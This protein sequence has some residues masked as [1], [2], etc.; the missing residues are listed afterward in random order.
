M[1]AFHSVYESRFTQDEVLTAGVSSG[2][3]A[4]LSSPEARAMG[5]IRS[6]P[7]TPDR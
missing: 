7:T 3:R 6:A 5:R 4:E 1:C 2:Q